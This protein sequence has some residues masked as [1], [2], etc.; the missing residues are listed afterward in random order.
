MCLAVDPPP[1]PAH[2]VRVPRTSDHGW[3]A[4]C[5]FSS[6]ASVA[7]EFNLGSHIEYSPAN[8]DSPVYAVIL[9]YL[10]I[11]FLNVMNYKMLLSLAGINIFHF[12]S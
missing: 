2:S 1:L 3:E 12:I 4:V 5:C 11:L 8:V 6:S 7:A 10:F 9:V